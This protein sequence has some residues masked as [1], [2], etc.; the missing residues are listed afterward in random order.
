VQGWA[1]TRLL[2][3]KG[4]MKGEGVITINQSLTPL[5]ESTRGSRSGT[6]WED[7]RR[8]LDLGKKVLVSP[9]EH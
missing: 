4:G 6:L 7:L 9:K 1:P 5:L 8:G 2:G 3:P